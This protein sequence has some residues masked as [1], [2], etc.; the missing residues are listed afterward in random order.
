MEQ[1]GLRY[2]FATNL[3]RLGE[4]RLELRITKQKILF[5]LTE[6]FY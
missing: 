3:F 6:I 4:I 2:H 5:F 1:D